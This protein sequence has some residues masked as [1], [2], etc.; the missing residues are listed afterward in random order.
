M[1]LKRNSFSWYSTSSTVL[2]L[3]YL[4]KGLENFLKAHG[5]IEKGY[6]LVIDPMWTG[7]NFC[8]TIAMKRIEA[9][10]YSCHL[11]VLSSTQ[12]REKVWMYPQP[13]PNAKVPIMII[14][15]P[16]CTK[17]KRQCIP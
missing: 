2:F 13:E 14:Y 10:F 15:M 12:L 5:E 1:G 6:L 8:V 16:I 11:Q 7:L 4:D 17:T 9:N 3:C